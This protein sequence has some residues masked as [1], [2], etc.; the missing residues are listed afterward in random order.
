MGDDAIHQGHCTRAVCRY[1]DPQCPVCRGEFPGGRAEIALS[2]LKDADMVRPRAEQYAVRN[3]MTGHVY[4][5]ANKPPKAAVTDL[6]KARWQRQKL[7]GD[8]ADQGFFEIVKR[9][10]GDWEVV[11]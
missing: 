5:P 8:G 1:G 6:D 9:P 4:A 3:R 11:E 2:V 10:V 7:A